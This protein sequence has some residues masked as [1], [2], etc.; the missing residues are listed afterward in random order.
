MSM[1]S[2]P[3]GTGRTRRR[4][5]LLAVLLA[6]AAPLIVW[7]V[8]V[9][10]L[11]IA[12]S[13]RLSPGAPATTIS[14]VVV[15]VVGALAGLVAWGLL[16]LLERTTA[17]PRAIWMSISIVVLVLSL[18]GPLGAATTPSAKVVLVCM[19]LVVATALVPLMATTVTRRRSP[20]RKLR[21]SESRANP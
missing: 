16:A 10:I 3:S 21:P 7:I 4:V 8:A 18:A 1:Q 11:G 19:H 17:H 14:P 15:V 13:A 6:V 20:D 9:P 2:T 5:R 12:L